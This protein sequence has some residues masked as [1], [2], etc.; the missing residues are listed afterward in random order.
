[1]I[2]RIRPL[3]QL[4]ASAAQ[5]ALEI[6]LAPSVKT[7]AIDLVMIELVLLNL[8]RNGIDAMSDTPSDQRRLTIEARMSDDSAQGQTVLWRVGDRG[9]GVSPEAD[10]QLFAPFY[11]T[12]PEGMGMGLNICRTIIEQHQGRIWHEPR[13]GGGAWFCFTV[14]APGAVETPSETEALGAAL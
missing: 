10:A 11:S 5:V 9:P 12:K 13:E 7:I 2:A 14:R 4:R 6:S 3:M 1:V 8:A